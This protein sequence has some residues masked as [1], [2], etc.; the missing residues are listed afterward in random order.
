MAEHDF[1]PAGLE[2]VDRLWATTLD[3][4]DIRRKL[5]TILGVKL[6][7]EQVVAAARRN[8]AAVVRKPAIAMTKIKR[9]AI[10]VDTSVVRLVPAGSYPARGFSMIGGKVK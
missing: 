1:S 9:S 7:D 10:P 2:L 6:T 8:A 5:Q 3:L 4:A